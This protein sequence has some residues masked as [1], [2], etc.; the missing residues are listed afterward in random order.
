MISSETIICAAPNPWDSPWRNRH[1]I[2]SRLARQNRV[3]YM[4]PRPYLRAVLRQ[5]RQLWQQ[6][7]RWQEALPNLYIYRPL[8]WAPVSGQT[9]LRQ[10]FAGWRRLDLAR[11]LRRLGP[12]RPILWLV[13]PDQ[14][15]MIG[16]WNEKLIV[17][18]VVDDYTAYEAGFARQKR[19]AWLRQL[20]DTM[21]RRADLV[22]CTHPDLCR[23]KTAVNPH[24]AYVPNAVDWYRFQ[25]ALTEP[26]PPIFDQLPR[27][28]IGYVGVINDKIDLTLLRQVAIAYPRGTLLLVG[29][30]S[31]R[32]RTEEWQALQLP[33]V[34]ALGR[35][36]VSAV[37]HF[38]KG[39]DVALMP[40]QLNAWTAS[41]DPLK[42]YEYLACGL[43]VVSTPI[44]A[45]KNFAEALY[46][47]ASENFVTAVGQ[48]LLE[49]TPEKR[50]YRQT[51][52]RTHSWE[53]RVESISTHLQKALLRR[54]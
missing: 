34:R 36:P 53:N 20:D 5:P 49:D 31:L 52:V 17:Y 46:I 14:G 54:R 27:P 44:P 39:C 10:L 3:V 30:L 9:P 47:A 6:G 26:L 29:P 12:E 32:F 15:D 2:M 50:V 23:Q 45:A 16:Q 28:V 4:E 7:P 1:Q 38:M 40:Y 24:C 33:N 11:H 25:K 41:I 43:P 13:S 21:T 18:H 19:L 42:M 35:Q 48:A 8:P 22:I 51:L 37:P